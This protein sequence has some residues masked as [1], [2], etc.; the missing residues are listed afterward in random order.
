MREPKDRLCVALD[1]PKLGEAESLVRELS[2]SVGMF[3]IGLELYSAAGPRAVE[4][5]RELGGRV[6]LDLKFHDIPNTVS[7]AARVVTRLGAAFFNIHTSGG[8]AMLRATTDA[9]ADEAVKAGIEKPG[10]L[11]VTVLTSV[12]AAV[13]HDELAVSREL[14]EHVIALA[15]MAQDCGLTGVVASAQEAR[16]VRNACGAGFTIVTPGIRQRGGNLADQRRVT[17]PAEALALGAD[18]IVVGRP[19]LDA[20]DRAAACRAIVDELAGSL[21][22]A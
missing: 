21:Q 17:T 2:D 1:V 18:Y 15:R 5:V 20:P 13:L 8:S 4:R 11:G 14:T 7:R 9:V 10:V 12:P 3:K 16:M 19:I 22:H 6:F